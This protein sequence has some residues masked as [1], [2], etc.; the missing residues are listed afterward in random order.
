[1]VSMFWVSVQSR[2]WEWLTFESNPGEQQG[3]RQ[4]SDYI[5]ITFNQRGQVGTHDNEPKIL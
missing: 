2:E 4:K 3:T 1:M 5:Y